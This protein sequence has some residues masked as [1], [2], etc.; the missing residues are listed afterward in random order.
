MK[1]LPSDKIPHARGSVLHDW[2]AEILA[3]RGLN[4]ALIQECHN[5]TE[6]HEFQSLYVRRRDPSE[7]LSSAGLQPFAIHEDV[8]IHMY[9]SEAPCGDASMELTMNA[10]QDPTPW[11]LPARRSEQEDPISLLNGRSYFSELGVVRRKP[12]MDIDCRTFSDELM[13]ET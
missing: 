1:C 3:I 5:L 2:H 9:C 4:L 8:K 13:V 11:T 12:C 6:S 7:L 10:Q